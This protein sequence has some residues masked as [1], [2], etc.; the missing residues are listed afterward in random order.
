MTTL[1]EASTSRGSESAS[2]GA[3]RL[4]YFPE[5]NGLRGVSILAVMAFHADESFL[6][7]GFIGVD[8]FFV[9]SGF[10]ITALLLQE[11]DRSQTISL[12]KF[13]L[14]RVLRLAPALLLF[15]AAYCAGSIILKGFPGAY[16]HLEEALI[17]LFYSTNWSRAL[18]IHPPF[19]L[20]HTWSLSIEEQFYV[21]WPPL[22][23]LLLGKTRSRRVVAMIAGGIAL[24]AWGLR[25]GLGLAGSTPMRLYNGSDTRAD[26]VMVGC[27]LGILVSSNLVPR[28]IEGRSAQ[29]LSLAGVLS[30][31]ALAWISATASWDSPAMLYGLY[32]AIELMTAV[33]ILDCFTNPRSVMKRLLSLPAVV[34]IGGISYGLYLW[35]YPIYMLLRDTGAKRWQVLAAGTAISF[36]VATLSYYLLER[37]F[38][39]LKKRL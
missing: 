34:W 7:A 24:S 37:R 30:I 39:Q 13:Y 9:L 18:E 33:I 23:L 19:Y 38:L 8:L 26:A 32:F 21:V 36:A 25:I 14:R 1:T 31:G 10:L 12:K 2:D 35:H 20:G 29:L 27:L 4:G 11:F 15:L 17:A 5:L 3:F 16:Y 22:L 6:K 28:R